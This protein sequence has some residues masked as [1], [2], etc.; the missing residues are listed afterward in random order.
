MRELQDKLETL[1]GITSDLEIY[2]PLAVVLFGSL[3]RLIR[4]LPLAHPPRDIDMLVVGDNVPAGITEK[5]ATIPLELQRFR[6]H[7]FLAMARSL[8]YDPKPLALTKLYSNQLAHKHARR[9]IAACLLLGPGY[10]Q[11]GIEQIEIDG[12]E[13]TRDYSVHQVLHGE[14]WWRQISSFARERRGP[15]KRFSD[16]I[17]GRDRFVAEGPT[18]R[19]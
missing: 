8:R 6:S 15:L 13:D 10:R 9:V 5:Y 17:A 2:R 12:V 7:A 18:R 19:H 3:A 4:G 14:R 1:S 16:K 11:F